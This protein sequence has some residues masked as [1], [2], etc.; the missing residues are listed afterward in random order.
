MDTSF[1]AYEIHQLRLLDEA[2]EA[3]IE[4][5]RLQAQFNEEIRNMK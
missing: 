3:Q 5:K 1:E 2:R 4:F